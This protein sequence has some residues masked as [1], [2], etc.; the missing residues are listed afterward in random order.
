MNDLHSPALSDIFKGTCQKRR[1]VNLVHV[2]LNLLQKVLWIQSSETQFLFLMMGTHLKLGFEK[3][4]RVWRVFRLY[5]DMPV[6]MSTWSS[7][8]EHYNRAQ[9]SVGSWHECLFSNPLN[10]SSGELHLCHQRSVTRSHVKG[11]LAPNSPKDSQDHW[12]PGQ[13]GQSLLVTVTR[14]SDRFFS[15]LPSAPTTWYSFLYWRKLK[16]LSGKILSFCS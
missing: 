10:L 6:G 9:V 3:F 2:K 16:I 15:L 7:V 1:A 11:W 8:A 12:F 5:D 14:N 13:S 4:L